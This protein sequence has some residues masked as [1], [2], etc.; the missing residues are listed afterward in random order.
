MSVSTGVPRLGAALVLALLMLSL[1]GVFSAS[2][3]HRA[4]EATGPSCSSMSACAP[5]SDITQSCSGLVQ[6]ETSELRIPDPVTLR[7]A[8]A[9]LS[10]DA[11][12]LSLQKPPPRSA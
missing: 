12:T 8:Q 10:P 2:S 6:D 1:A 7:A 11:V 3:M 9:N 5:S 4:A